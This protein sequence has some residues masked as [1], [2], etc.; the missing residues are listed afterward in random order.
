MKTFTL[1]LLLGISESP[2]KYLT[3]NSLTWSRNHGEKLNLLDGKTFKKT[4]KKHPP[5]LTAGFTPTWIVH[6][7]L[8][9]RKSLFGSIWNRTFFWGQTKCREKGQ[10]WSKRFLKI[11]LSFASSLAQQFGARSNDC[12]SNRSGWAISNGSNSILKGQDNQ[13]MFLL[14]VFFVWGTWISM[15][16]E[17]ITHLISSFS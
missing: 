8:L 1:D 17:R 10:C 6:W 4:L 9:L 3:Q 15:N 5:K 12:F 7:I 2:Q 14:P 13:S 16:L 11:S